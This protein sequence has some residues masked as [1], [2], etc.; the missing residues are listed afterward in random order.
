L[1]NRFRYWDLEERYAKL[2]LWVFNN[3]GASVNASW[4]V[5]LVRLLAE[6]LT[7]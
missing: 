3:S 6:R 7:R 5:S 4:R 2:H 1:R